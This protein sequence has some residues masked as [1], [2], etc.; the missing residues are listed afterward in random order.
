MH[1]ILPT[2]GVF[3]LSSM[4][5]TI[6]NVMLSPSRAVQKFRSILLR[7]LLKSVLKE[8]Q[9]FVPISHVKNDVVTVLRLKICYW[10]MYSTSCVTRNSQ[11]NKR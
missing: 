3:G 2:G 1:S 10:S 9:Y 7:C 6:A 8:I 5:V 11:I 4:A